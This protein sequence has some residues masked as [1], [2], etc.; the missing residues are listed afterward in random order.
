METADIYIEVI[1]PSFIHQVQEHEW[2]PGVRFLW[3]KPMNSADEQLFQTYVAAVEKAYGAT[4]VLG[5]MGAKFEK[6][7]QAAMRKTIQ[8]YTADWESVF[9]ESP[10]GTSIAVKTK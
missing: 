5:S 3:E 8:Q 6:Q 2:L 9:G 7:V 4:F 10:F 1:R